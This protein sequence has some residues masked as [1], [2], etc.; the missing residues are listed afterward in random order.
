MRA[1]RC[2]SADSFCVSKQT[3][4]YEV[5]SPRTARRVRQAGGVE[6]VLSAVWSSLP[7]GRA[8]GYRHEQPWTLKSL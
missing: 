7:P 5:T 3:A 2:Y 8:D 1:H 6:P 4:A